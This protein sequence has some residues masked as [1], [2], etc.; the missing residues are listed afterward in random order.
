MIKRQPWAALA[1]YTVFSLASL[2][3][4]AIAIAGLVLGREAA[5]GQI[6]D[7]LREC[8]AATGLVATIM[9]VVA[10]LIGASGAGSRRPRSIRFGRLQPKPDLL[11]RFV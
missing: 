3:L 4:I 11:I 6:L 9:G 2:L 10:L 7:Q 1:Y 5:Q 8:E